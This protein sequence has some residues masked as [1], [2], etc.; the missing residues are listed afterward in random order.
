M[1]RSYLCS[2]IDID[3]PQL[4]D[5]GLNCMYFLFT[6]RS[7]CL[8]QYLIEKEENHDLLNAFLRV[9]KSTSADHRKSFLMALRMLL[10][11]PNPGPE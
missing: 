2:P 8:I 9:A 7:H 1:L 5:I 10:K 11:I 6:R 3:K 4:K